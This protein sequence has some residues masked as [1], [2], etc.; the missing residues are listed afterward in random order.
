MKIFGCRQGTITFPK[1][2]R[3]NEPAGFRVAYFRNENYPDFPCAVASWEV[4]PWAFVRVLQIYRSLQF[5]ENVVKALQEAYDSG[6]EEFHLPK[7][8]TE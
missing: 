5:A 8:P 6:A 1:E 7:E 2:S 4:C 3:K